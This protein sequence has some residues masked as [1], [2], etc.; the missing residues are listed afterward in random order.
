M[1]DEYYLQGF[2]GA[3]YSSFLNQYEEIIR[4][5]NQ[6][7]KVLKVTFDIVFIRIRNGRKIQKT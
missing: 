7:K 1:L 4:D 6:G 5:Q 2:A 3:T